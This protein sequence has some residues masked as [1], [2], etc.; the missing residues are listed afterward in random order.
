[1]PTEMSVL[2]TCASVIL[3][4]DLLILQVTAVSASSIVKFFHKGDQYN[5]QFVAGLLT[6]PRLCGCHVFFGM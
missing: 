2:S 1:M 5:E 3:R 4:T 6:R